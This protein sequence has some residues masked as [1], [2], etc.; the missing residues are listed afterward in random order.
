MDQILIYGKGEHASGVTVHDRESAH[1]IVAALK[2]SGWKIV[3][4][5]HTTDECYP[6]R[7]YEKD[8]ED[9]KKLSD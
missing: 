8:Y 7:G 3:W 4:T 1:R 5:V 9:W 6:M 2:K